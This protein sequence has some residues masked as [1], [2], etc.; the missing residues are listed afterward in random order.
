M[1]RGNITSLGAGVTFLSAI[2]NDSSGN[3]I[4]RLIGADTRIEPYIQ[5]DSSRPTTLKTRY[6]AAGQQ[7]LR[8]DTR[9]RHADF[10]GN[11]PGS[12]GYHP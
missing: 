12:G 8:T 3:E 2:G 9:K 1:W 10:A 6:V 5:R 7:L 4:L 11:P